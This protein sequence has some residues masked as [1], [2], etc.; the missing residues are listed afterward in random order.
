MDFLTRRG[1]ILAELET[2]GLVMQELKDKCAF[3]GTTA[4]DPTLLYVAEHARRSAALDWR[5]NRVSQPRCLVC[6]GP[7]DSTI[8]W[9]EDSFEHCTAVACSRR[10]RHST[11]FSA[12]T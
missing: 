10:F 7:N 9:M 4:A 6:G 5:S 1:A 12:T 8:K 3:F 2:L 11:D